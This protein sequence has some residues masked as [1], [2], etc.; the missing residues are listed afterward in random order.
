MTRVN[1]DQL[2]DVLSVEQAARVM[3][4]GR[5]T[6]YEAA[7]RDEIP[8]IRIGNRILVS[9]HALMAKLGLRAMAGSAL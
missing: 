3:G 4:I 2:P 7:R 8:H 9:K 1:F 5:N 6:A